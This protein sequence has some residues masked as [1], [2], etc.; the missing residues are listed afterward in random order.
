MQLDKTKKKTIRKL[1]VAKIFFRNWYNMYRWAL[2]F[3]TDSLPNQ[4]KLADYA[5]A[6]YNT[7][8]KGGEGHLEIGKNIMSAQDKHA[9]MVVSLKPFGCIPSTMSDGVQSNVVADYKDAIFIPIETS[10]DGEVNVRSHVQMRLYEAKM[11]ARQEIKD[12]LEE[13]NVTMEQVKE[14]TSKR[15]KYRN[16]M[17]NV[18]SH[19]GISTAANLVSMVGKHA[20]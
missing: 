2:G 6:Y 7:H 20:K 18:P 17:L 15:P 3:K 14:Y 16:P 9:Q 19:H 5:K 8:L 13:H 4:Q 12:V 10:G 1:N 11:K